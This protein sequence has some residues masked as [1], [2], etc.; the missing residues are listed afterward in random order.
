METTLRHS[1]VKLPENPDQH[2]EKATHFTEEGKHAGTATAG[3]TGQGELGSRGPSLKGQARSSR[4][5][6]VTF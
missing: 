2:L 4:Q 5:S 3:A 6:S 1:P